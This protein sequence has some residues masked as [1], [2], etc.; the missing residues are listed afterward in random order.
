MLYS[1][2]WRLII[3]YAALT[4]LTILL[5]GVVALSLLTR[6]M[7]AR[8]YET[9]VLNAEA[10]ARMAKPLL[11]RSNQGLRLQQL[12]ITSGFLTNTELTIL[13]RDHRALAHSQMRLAPLDSRPA[14]LSLLSDLSRSDRESWLKGM[15]SPVIVISGSGHPRGM[16]AMDLDEGGTKNEEAAALSLERRPGFLGDRLVIVDPGDASSDNGDTTQNRPVTL[17]VLSTPRIWRIVFGYAPEA[18][19]QPAEGPQVT[20]PVQHDEQVVGYVQMT[21]RFTFFA[22]P[23]LAIRRALIVAGM[24]AVLVAVILGFLMS[25]TLTAPLM[26]LE[27]ATQQMEEGDLAV[28]APETGGEIG[29]L[30]RRFNRMAARL[31]ASFADL[32]AERDALRRFIADAS[33][34]LRTP[35]TALRQFIEILQGKAGSE[36]ETRTEFLGESQRQ[37][38]RLQWMTGHLLDLSRL[39]GGVAALDVAKHDLSDLLQEALSPFRSTAAAKQIELC[40]SVPDGLDSIWCDRTSLGMA[41]ANLLDNA[42][43]FTQPGGFVELAASAE[44]HATLLTVSD[45]GPGIP[46]SDLERIFERFYRGEISEQLP[47]VGL[48]LAIVKSAV[49]AHGGNVSVENRDGAFFTIELPTHRSERQPGTPPA[50]LA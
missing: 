17:D 28:R 25:R 43:K 12:A 32:A 33:H 21:N 42:L 9:L 5:I 3:S 22:E 44:A 34:E 39:E 49:E 41:L 11:V 38:E 7:A 46:P 13:D 23:L 31:Q 37:L 48:G 10:V 30:A 47:G 26:A 2:R 50:P 20:V 36:P 15:V 6:Y 18:V 40:L 35:L 45:S 19:P 8:E 27:G 24:G 16:I 29:D 1:I 14:L 4:L